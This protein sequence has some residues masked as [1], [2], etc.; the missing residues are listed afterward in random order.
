MQYRPNGLGWCEQGKRAL[1]GLAMLVT[2]N[3][4][5]RQ[6]CCILGSTGDDEVVETGMV[7]DEAQQPVGQKMAKSKEN[8]FGKG[9]GGRDHDHDDGLGRFQMEDF[10]ERNR[11][12]WLAS[13]EV[14]R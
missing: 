8:V 4:Q 3:L 10:G 7:A 1:N 9:F 5:W 14:A 12:R 13:Q 11:S 2:E 6:G